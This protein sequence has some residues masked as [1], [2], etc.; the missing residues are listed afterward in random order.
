MEQ[1]EFEALNK[2]WINLAQPIFPTLSET[3][4]VHLRYTASID[5]NWALEENS[6]SDPK[7]VRLFEQYIVMKR[8]LK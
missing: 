7:L 8:L 2:L 5:W 6:G 3:E 1:A 4:L